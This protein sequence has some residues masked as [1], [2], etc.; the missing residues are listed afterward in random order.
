MIISVFV[1]LPGL[2]VP[3]QFFEETD[4]LNLWT[5]YGISARYYF[6]Y[7]SRNGAPSAT[8]H[9]DTCTRINHHVSNYSCTCAE[10]MRCKTVSQITQPNMGFCI[11]MVALS[12]TRSLYV[13]HDRSQILSLHVTFTFYCIHT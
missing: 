13:Q 7:E 3:G 8:G 11:E 10:Q 5:P 9:L 6:S 1:M 2:V 12:V 4:P